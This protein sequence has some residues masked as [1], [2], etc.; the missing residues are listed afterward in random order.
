MGNSSFPKS[1]SLDIFDAAARHLNFTKAGD[2]LGLTPA[3]VSY[4]IKSI[5]DRL[6]FL[7]FE[8]T[9]RKMSL[10]PAGV[11]MFKAVRNAINALHL[12]VNQAKKTLVNSSQL[13]ISLG[14]RF[15]TNWLLPRLPSFTRDYPE[16]K[17]IFDL[18][19]EVRDL[20][21]EE[22]DIAIRFGSDS[23]PNTQSYKLF[24]TTVIPVCR[25]EFLR[26]K[27]FIKS[28]EQIQKQRLCYVDCHTK[29][30][31]WPNWISLMEQAGVDN[32]DDSQAIPFS[33][34][35][36]VVQAILENDMIGLA[37]TCMIES[38]LASGKLVKILD[39]EMTVSDQDAYHLLYSTSQ[40]QE[41]KII[42]FRNWLLGEV[43]SLSL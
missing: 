42:A 18:S 2:E 6:G 12:G 25:P 1:S 36:H 30:G 24:T 17:I 13:H 43:S 28:I 26:S 7:L 14:A 41:P 40:S 31:P 15:A 19:D 38:E 20:A 16:I 8:R 39:M 37:E 5:E 33:E 23:Y 35:S 4:Q 34:L 11:I 3:A 9:S 27:P 10:T 22:V 21:S 29:S 32:F